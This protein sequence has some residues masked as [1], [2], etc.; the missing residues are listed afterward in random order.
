MGKIVNSFKSMKQRSQRAI[1]K[2]NGKLKLPFTLTNL[3]SNSIAKK[4]IVFGVLLVLVIIVSLQVIA[5]SYSKGTLIDITSKQA[6]MLAEQHSS[7]IDSWLE[8]ISESTKSAASK[9]VMTTD[10]DQLIKEQFHLL[11]Q[12][13]RE[14]TRV[15]LVDGNTG[16]ALYSLTGKSDIDFTTKGYFKQA[17]DNKTTVFSDEEIVRNAEKSFI[18]I[19]SPIGDNNDNNARIL[20]VGFNL[21]SLLKDVKEMPFMQ[22]GYA[23]IVNKSGLVVAHRNQ[24]NNNQLE[25]SKDDHYKEMLQFMQKEQSNS[26]IY[27]DNGVSSFAAFAPIKSLH[28]NIVLTTPVSEVYG[29]VNAMG[30]VFWIFSIP[31]ILIASFLIWWFAKRIRTQLFGISQDMQRIGRGDLGVQ[32]QVK[33]SDEFAQLGTSMNEMVTELRQIISLVQG[34]ASQL[35]TAADDLNVFAQGNKQAIDI[36]STNISSISERVQVQTTEVQ[37]AASTVSEISQGVEQV[38]VAAEQTSLATSRTY[39]RAQGGQALVD[40]VIT[41][42]RSASNEVEVTAERMHNMRDRAKEIT[43]IVEMIRSIAS[44]TNLLALNA[45]IE[46]ARAGEAGKGF[47]VVATEVRKLAEESSTFSEK[48]AEIARSINDESM[49]MSSNMDHI[50]TMVTQGLHSVESVGQSFQAILADIQAAAEQGES[51]TATAEEMA[52]GN[53]IVTSSMVR[54]ASMSDD[55]NES[56]SGVVETVDDQFNS[57]ARIN[58]SVEDLKNLA[59][60]L[61][62]SVRRFQV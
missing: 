19:A 9:R 61:T 41:N 21:N 62:E 12:S 5:L 51:M 59:D 47:S 44:Q 28:W 43:S 15:Y 31:V 58:E 38:A 46:A 6:K 60:D 37:G 55:I 34:Q 39:E 54:L 2:S 35:N 52:A 26:V 14:I 11:T 30:G 49:E 23:F 3:V 13:H 24:D 1:G 33:G 27:N 4:M 42:V 45:A 50:V 56:I 48:I 10:L 57:I 40:Q 53:Q 32:V 36:I 25:L 18:Y 8:G 29:E 20:I 22:D 16:K 17:H 7:T